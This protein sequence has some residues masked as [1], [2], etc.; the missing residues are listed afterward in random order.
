M[1]VALA[2]IWQSQDN[3]VVGRSGVTVVV[4]CA[5]R[6][7]EWV[8]VDRRESA[9]LERLNLVSAVSRVGG[10]TGGNVVQIE[11]VT[12]LPGNDVVGTRGVS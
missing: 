5:V 9:V 10:R 6:V 8:A 3:R 1:V 7:A 2:N 4:H 12:Q 11:F